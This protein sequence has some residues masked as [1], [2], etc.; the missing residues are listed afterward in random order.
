M[1]EGDVKMKA[2]KKWRILGVAAIIGAI[3]LLL[4][5]AGFALGQS[6]NTA[7]EMSI[8][9]TN[10]SFSDSVYIKYAV[11][12]KNLENADDI[13]LL[14]WTEGNGEYL[15]GS[16]SVAIFSGKTATVAGKKCLVFDY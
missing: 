15:I 6:G 7:P 13:R 11:E 1:N 4:A 10:L 2:N 9:A 14:V 16:E 3:S 8:I 12:Y 5:F